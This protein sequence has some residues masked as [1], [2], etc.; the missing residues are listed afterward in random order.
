MSRTFSFRDDV[1]GHVLIVS[2]DR[3]A[4]DAG[5]FA[6]QIGGT[7]VVSGFGALTATPAGSLLLSY[8][9]PA[10]LSPTFS[11]TGPAAT[12]AFS[13]RAVTI[14]LRA[15][16]VPDTML[17]D[18]TLAV[19][20]DRYGL[21]SRL[22]SVGDVPG[23]LD[24]LERAFL[25][26]DPA[27]LYPLLSSDITSTRTAEEFAADWKAKSAIDGRRMVGLIRGEAG[28]IEVLAIGYATMRVA[29][30][31]EIQR[32]SGTTSAPSVM[33]LIHQASGWKLWFT[34]EL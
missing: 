33:V 29:Y 4:R 17:A 13:T 26:D 25:A 12:P 1:A 34:S 14:S 16:L 19:G 30:R 9:G 28:P 15:T 20:S 32:P 27:A 31:V 5:H 7:S 22:P 18:A 21:T 24:R 11:L 8:D 6:F 3:E 10:T 23:L 2:I